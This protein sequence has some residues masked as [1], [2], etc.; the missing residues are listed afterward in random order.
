MSAWYTGVRGA[1]A[2]IFA[3]AIHGSRLMDAWGVNPNLILILIIVGVERTGRMA[4]GLGAAAAA[5]AA[6]LIWFPAFSDSAAAGACAALIASL[7]LMWA[8]GGRTATVGAIAGGT[9]LFYF[10]TAVLQGARVAPGVVV[11]EMLYNVL[12][13]MGA[14]ILLPHYARRITS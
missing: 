3:A 2:G 9:I 12:W 5:V 14:I 10:L 1:M 6:A 8:K 11:G 13:G 4:W 7:A